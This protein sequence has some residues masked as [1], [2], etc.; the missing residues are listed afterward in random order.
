MSEVVD[1]R[2]NISR[3]HLLGNAFL[4]QIVGE[5]LRICE[6]NGMRGILV[7][8]REGEAMIYPSPTAYDAALTMLGALEFAGDVL[9]GAAE[10]EDTSE[11]EGEPSV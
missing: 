8:E 3:E 4:E 6:V 11:E 5:L 10:I 7:L 1:I 9:K 2:P